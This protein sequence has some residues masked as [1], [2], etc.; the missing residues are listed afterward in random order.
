MSHEEWHVDERG[1]DFNYAQVRVPKG[2][3]PGGSFDDRTGGPASRR[4]Q[5]GGLFVQLNVENA[6]SNFQFG[7]NA[8]DRNVGFLVNEMVKYGIIKETASP[9]D[10]FSAYQKALKLTASISLQPGNLQKTSVLDAFK[11]MQGSG[12]T[13]GDGKGGTYKDFIKYTPEQTS[14]LAENTYQSILGRVPTG[15]ESRAFARAIA[16]GAKVAPAIRKVSST[17]KVTVNQKGFDE[18][19]FIAGYMADKI[20]DAGS[21]LDGIAGKVQDLIDNYKQNYGVAPTQGFINNAIKEVVKSGGATLDNMEQQL[22]EQAQ[23]LYPALKDK[24]NAGLSVRA[25][26]DPYISKTAKLLEKADMSIGLDNKYVS[27]ALSRKNDKGEYELMSL[28]DHAKSI[29]SSAEWLDTKNA[30]ETFLGAADSILATFGFIG[31]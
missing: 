8:G 26:A 21:D 1:T 24:I 23:V 17:G 6:L 14:R 16:A 25:I 19:A 31:R 29:R 27:S 2:V 5:T 30:K 3:I 12:L 7:Y 11:L 22:K 15:E 13:A 9:M 20:P 4:E 10:V 28:D 18:G